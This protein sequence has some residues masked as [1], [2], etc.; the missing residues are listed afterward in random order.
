MRPANL[1]CWPYDDAG[2]RTSEIENSTSSSSSSSS[3]FGGC[4]PSDDENRTINTEYD[5]DAT[6]RVDY[7]DLGRGTFVIADY[8]RLDVIWTLVELPGSNDTDTGD[9]NDGL[10]R[11]GRV[12]D[13]RGSSSDTAER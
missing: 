10:D 1:P 6:H 7:D 11:F 4:S 3:S 12:K 13:C 9:I 5:P 2:R 8:F